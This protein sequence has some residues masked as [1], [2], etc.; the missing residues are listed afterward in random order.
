M[1]AVISQE[2]QGRAH[3][4][5]DRDRLDVVNEL[6]RVLDDRMATAPVGSPLKD[7]LEA[8]KRSAENYRHAINQTAVG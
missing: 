7:S 1:E 8:Q 2:N 4:L 5:Y 6:E 3:V